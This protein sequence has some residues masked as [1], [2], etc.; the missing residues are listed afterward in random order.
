MSVRAFEVA[1]PGREALQRVRPRPHHVALTGI[2]GLAAFLNLWNLSQNAYAN[3]YY[4]AAVRS[5]LRS[6]HNFFFVSFDA[7]GLVSVDKPPLALWLQALSAKVFGF[8]SF[9]IL[10]PEALAGVGAVWLLYLLVARYFGRVAGLVAALA[11]AVSDRKSV[12]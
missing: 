8:S 2:L 6:W 9:S 3:T 12:V 11:L 7:G 5:M 10:L 1:V 4:A